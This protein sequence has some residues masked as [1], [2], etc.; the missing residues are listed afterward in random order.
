MSKA[1]YFSGGKLKMWTFYSLVTEAFFVALS[2]GLAVSALAVGLIFLLIRTRYDEEFSFRRTKFDTVILIFAVCSM[3]S[4]MV[5]PDKFFSAY[6][7]LNTGLLYILSY[8]LF[9][10][11]VDEEKQIHTVMKALAA[12]AVIVVLYGYYQYFFGIDISNI[13]WVDAEAFPELKKRVFSTWQNPNILA[14]YLDEAI[15]IVLGFFIYAENRKQK[16][17]CFVGMVLLAGCLAMTYARGACLAAAIVIAGYGAIKDRRI[18]LGCIVVGALIIAFNPALAE[19]LMSVFT[20]MDTSSE[21]RLA[22]WESSVAMIEEHPLF[23]IGWGAYWMVYHSYDFYINDP[24]VLI[25]HAHNIYLNYAAEIGLVGAFSFFGFFFG[26]LYNM[27]KKC[28]APV[29][30]FLKGLRLGIGLALVTVALGGMTDDVLFNIPTSIL[31]W[32]TC[33]IAVKTDELSK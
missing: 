8:E 19:R 20:K 27:L 10:Q 18:F 16:L 7:F 21:M 3:I 33:A 1:G 12:G 2:P 30:L 32:I 29:S 4:I 9:I 6:N 26:N 28:H 5:S 22:L 14:G 15:C 17:L 23:G 24:R 25:V 13:K 11:S 31:L